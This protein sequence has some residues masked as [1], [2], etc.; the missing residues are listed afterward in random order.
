[1]PPPADL[2][3]VVE[4]RSRVE[5]S[6]G[7][8]AD[9]SSTMLPAEDSFQ[10]PALQPEAYPSSEEDND[11]IFGDMPADDCPEKEP[12]LDGVSLLLFSSFTCSGNKYKHLWNGIAMTMFS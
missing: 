6:F 8:P 3:S 7:I 2:P 10:P 1:M 12:S 5:Q 9:Q 11:D 4:D